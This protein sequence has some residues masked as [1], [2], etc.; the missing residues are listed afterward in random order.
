MLRVPRL[1]LLERR[2]Y[3]ALVP[4]VSRVVRGTGDLVTLPW[5]FHEAVQAHKNAEVEQRRVESE[6]TSAYKEHAKAERLYTV[7][8]ARR[9]LMLK[10]QGMAITACET[11]A[12]GDEHIATLRYERNVAEGLK[13]TAK[14][15]AWRVNADRRDVEGLIDWSKRRDLAEY[16]RPAERE[17]A[18]KIPTFGGKR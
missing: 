11:V 12:K 17:P 1:V 9:I 7:A 2:A 16:C 3:K 8:L 13:E 14:V 4:R 10:S 6:V 5:S 18:H 15:A